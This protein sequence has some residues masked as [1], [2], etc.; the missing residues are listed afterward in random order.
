MMSTISVSQ[1]RTAAEIDDGPL[2]QP[3]TWVQIAVLGGLFI[4]LFSNMLYRAYG[5]SI[6]GEDVF[7]LRGYAWTDGDWSH[8]LVV[9]LISLYFLYQ[10]REQLRRATVRR[11][12]YGLALMIAGIVFYVLGIHPIRNDMVK[13]YSMIMALGGLV[14]FMGGWGVAR[15]ALFPVAY[16]VFAI[17]LSDMVWT[18]I[19]YQLQDIAAKCSAVAINLLGFPLGIEADLY[20]NS[21]DLWHAGQSIP[22]LNVAEACSGLR[23]LMTF[24][25]L[26]VAVAYL[27]ERPWWARLVLVLLTVPV[28]ILVNVGRVTAMGLLAPYAP[29]AIKGDTHV[30]IGLLML[31]PAGLLFLGIGWVLNQLVIVEEDE[32]A[33]VSAGGHEEVGR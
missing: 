6:G 9:P 23:M 10:H 1:T 29:D 12:G 18:R 14:W 21:I 30:L 5:I 15:V 24:I 33:A 11:S 26:G 13:G 20:G 3:H 7:A 28:A 19:A 22:G 31:I 2:I 8:A 32:P 16:L 27:A 4:A 17:K 25:A